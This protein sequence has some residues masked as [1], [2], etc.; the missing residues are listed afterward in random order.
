MENGLWQTKLE[1]GKKITA[2]IQ[3]Y[4]VG[5]RFVDEFQKYLS[6]KIDRN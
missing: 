4:T 3:D 1:A 2:V 6:S 5:I